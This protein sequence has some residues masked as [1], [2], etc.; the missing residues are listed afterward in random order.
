MNITCLHMKGVHAEVN[1]SNKTSRK[2]T[3]CKPKDKFYVK[4]QVVAARFVNTTTRIRVKISPMMKRDDNTESKPDEYLQHWKRSNTYG[5]PKSIL[6]VK[7]K[8]RVRRGI[9]SKA[10]FSAAKLCKKS[11]SLSSRMGMERVKPRFQPNVNERQCQQ[12]THGKQ[13][14]P[15]PQ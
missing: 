8:P 2:P 14:Q 10:Q 4:K 13:R 3:T 5:T 7:S 15:Q 6:K 11:G 9:K 12:Q 1:K